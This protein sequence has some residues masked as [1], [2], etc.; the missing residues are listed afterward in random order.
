MTV[1]VYSTRFFNGIDSV[2]GA[3]Y[4]VPAGFRA[5]LRDFWVV[6][7]TLNVNDVV[8]LRVAGA[9]VWAQ[10]FTAAQLQYYFWQGRQVAEAGE[11]IGVDVTSLAG[12]DYSCSGYL[13]TL[14]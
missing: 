8:A 9:R 3:N 12:L 7:T 1:A 6:G 13:L 5:V 14:P 11:S 4:V 10:I 2:S